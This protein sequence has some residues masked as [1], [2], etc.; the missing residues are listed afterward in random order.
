M[1]IWIETLLVFVSILLI[2]GYFQYRKN[3]DV[4][5]IGQEMLRP[6]YLAPALLSALI[7]FIVK[8]VFTGL[9]TI[10]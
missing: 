6:A 10:L 5:A 1:N 2:L 9:D 8:L 3:P 7:Y 4:I